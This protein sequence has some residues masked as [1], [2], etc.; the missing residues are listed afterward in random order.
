MFMHLYAPNDAIDRRQLWAL[1]TNIKA[2]F[3]K[4][5]CVR[6]NFNEIKSI[7]ERKGCIRRDSEWQTLVTSLVA[8]PRLTSLCWEGN[9][10]GAIQWKVRD[11]AG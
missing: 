7:E 2:V 6:E 11:E 8:W 9:I 4:P 1:L 3:P 5:W 10:V